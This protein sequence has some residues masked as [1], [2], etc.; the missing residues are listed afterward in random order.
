MSPKARTIAFWTLSAILAAFFLMSGA[1]KLMNQETA[2]GVNFD[3]QFELW[4]LPAWFRFPVGLAEIAGAIGLLVP[5]LRFYAAAGL[6]LLMIGGA[7]THLRVG[8]YAFAPIPLVL[9]LLVGT[10]AW[11][12]KPAW[13]DAR[14]GRAQT[15]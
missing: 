11:N 14:L 6:T 8:E 1:G 9:A 10:I 3:R 12:H 2:E 5:R 4:G 13:V 15:A 7:M